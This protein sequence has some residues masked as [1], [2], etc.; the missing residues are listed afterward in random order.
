MTLQ[1][2]KRFIE[3][4]LNILTKLNNGFKRQLMEFEKEIRN[5]AEASHDFFVLP[6]RVSTPPVQFR[7]LD[8]FVRA[9]YG[10]PH[11]CY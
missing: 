1:L 10:P 3:E 6:K 5:V 4:E 7:T 2:A 11:Q 9:M 8:H